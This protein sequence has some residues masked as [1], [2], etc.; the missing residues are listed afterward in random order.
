MRCMV[1]ISDLPR[2]NRPRYIVTEGVAA[3]VQMPSAATGLTQMGVHV[4]YIEP[5]YAGTHRHFHSVEE[6]WTYVLAGRGAK[7]YGA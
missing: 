3:I 7:C 2:E 6:E 5:G 1:N 4:R